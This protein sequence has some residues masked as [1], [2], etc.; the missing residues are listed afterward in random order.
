MVSEP[1]SGLVLAVSKDRAL[2]GP[3]AAGLFVSLVAAAERVARRDG[4]RLSPQLAHLRD[5]LR[6]V[7]MSDKRHC[8]VRNT[9]DLRSWHPDEITTAEA[10]RMLARSPR[11]TQRLAAE[12]AF[13]PVRR[14]GRG[15]LIPRAEVAAY[16]AQREDQV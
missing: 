13:G 1:W 7:A 10:A 5:V 12:G 2:I 6:P 4:I 14:V 9:P 15:Y 3:E 11:Q 8:D 16:A